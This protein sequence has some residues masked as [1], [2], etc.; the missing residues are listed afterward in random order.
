MAKKAIWK[1]AKK[2]KKNK[3]KTE[4]QKEVEFDYD[5]S[6]LFHWLSLNKDKRMW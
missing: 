5:F 3:K 4:K 6:E 2:K 1:K